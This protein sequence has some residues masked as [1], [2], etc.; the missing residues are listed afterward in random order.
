MLSCHDLDDNHDEEDLLNEGPEF[1]AGDDAIAIRVKELES[2]S[3][4]KD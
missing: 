3:E 4:K 1:L 2:L